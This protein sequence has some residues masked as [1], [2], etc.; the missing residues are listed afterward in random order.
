MKSKLVLINFIITLISV[1]SFAQ[2][3]ENSPY[4]R[5][6]IGD[7]T[8]NNFAFLRGSG[9]SGS[10]YSGD[11]LNITNPASY[12]F[13]NTTIFD[14]GF[15]SK[16]SSY[17]TGNNSTNVASGN[18]D[19]ISLGMP[20][21]NPINDLLERKEKKYDLGLNFTLMP[22]SIVGYNIK[23][24]IEDENIGTIRKIYKGYGGTYKFTTGLGGRYKN[25]AV[26][27]NAGYF[28]GKMNYDR[29]IL[30]DDIEY[31]YENNY[32]E[33]LGVGGFLYNAGI[34]YNVRL[35]AKKA[36]EKNI[37]PDRLQF[38]IY[39]NT[40]T[41]FSTYNSTLNINTPSGL[42]ESIIDTSY[43][44][45]AKGKGKLPL[46]YGGGI[47]YNHQEKLIIGVNYNTTKWRDYEN[48][49]HPESFKD[50]YEAG[51]GI[52]YTPDEFSYTNYMKKIKYRANVYYKTDPR[53]EE[54]IQFDEKGFHLGFGFPLVYQRKF[55]NLNTD[56]N[57][58]TRGN[59][60]SISE[61]FVKISFSVTFNDSEWFIKRK[62]Y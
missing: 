37:K 61:N 42:S 60:L 53:N 17:N 57:F 8:D 20:L 16:F 1:I 55:A 4:S 50:S 36:K 10:F 24:T 34:M 59:K 14:I 38:G 43:C 30:F 31:P 45:D 49:L 56:F 35:N 15:Y 25:L 19:Y 52:Q 46:S 11:Q 29:E 51:F 32:H 3:K 13:I 12:G 18:L 5:F 21:L 47:S 48:E 54:G 7:L 22:N 33:D 26:G 39:G 23:S 28:F 44:D 6:G 2:P 27:F 40:S 58:G 62:Y 9:L 41:K